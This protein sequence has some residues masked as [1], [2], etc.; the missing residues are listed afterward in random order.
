MRCNGGLFG[1]L[2]KLFYPHPFADQQFV[3]KTA[4]E[5]ASVRKLDAFWCEFVKSMKSSTAVA[6]GEFV[7][8]LIA[9]CSKEVRRQ[10]AGGSTHGT[11]RLLDQWWVAERYPS[12]CM[13]SV[14]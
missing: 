12:V 7:E 1:R 5:V 14:P 6:K 9:S 3:E 11:Q 4:L 2:P 8:E 13:T 10:P